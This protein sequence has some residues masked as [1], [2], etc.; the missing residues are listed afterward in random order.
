MILIA[1]PA[2]LGAIKE[3]GEF[4]DAR[5][6]VDTDALRAFQAIARDRPPLIVLESGFAATSRGT[7]LVQRIKADPLLSACEVQVVSVETAAAT[8]AADPAPAA[9]STLDPDGT[10]RAA[11]FEI[12]AGIELL[13]DGNPAT[14]ID[15]SSSGAQVIS[16]TSLKPNQRVRLTLPG[17]IPIRV[18]GEIAWAVFEMPRTGACYRAGVVFIDADVAAIDRF[19]AAN[20]KP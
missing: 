7:A 6:F 20:S 2:Y 1:A 3:R 19:I 9:V 14:L 5:T 11:R 8:A 4:R 16:P 12:A 17:R 13:V 18:N 15:L 10:R